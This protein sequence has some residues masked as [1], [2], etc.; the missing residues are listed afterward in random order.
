MH[1]DICLSNPEPIVAWIDAF[2]RE[3]YEIRQILEVE[4][5][6]DSAAVEDV[7]QKCFEARQLWLA[8]DFNRSDKAARPTA[9]MPTM[10]EA[11]FGTRLM[12]YQRRF[13]GGGQGKNEGRK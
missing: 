5:T 6:P 4:G 8:G 11:F 10:G 12:E 7:F 3:L 13:L 2:I 9:D 1:R